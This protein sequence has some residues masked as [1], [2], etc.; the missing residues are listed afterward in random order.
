MGE[1]IQEEMMGEKG[2]VQERCLTPIR[3]NI[4]DHTTSR[5]EALRSSMA[6]DIDW[7]SRSSEA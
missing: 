4:C 6:R 3:A 7:S 5:D 2:L 1:A